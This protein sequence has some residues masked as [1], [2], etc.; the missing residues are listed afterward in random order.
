MI[1]FWCKIIDYIHEDLLSCELD[2]PDDCGDDRGICSH[3]DEYKGECE[4]CHSSYNDLGSSHYIRSIDLELCES[5]Y[6]AGLIKEKAIPKDSM[7]YAGR[8][9]KYGRISIEI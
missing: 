2:C 3:N 6:D 9:N 5:C 4:I 1:S 8:Y 7:V